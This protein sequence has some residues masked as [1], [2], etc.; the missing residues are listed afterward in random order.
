M[1][2]RPSL[3][4]IPVPIDSWDVFHHLFAWDTRPMS[5]QANPSDAVLP[6]TLGVAVRSFFAQGGRKC[7]V[8]SVGEPWPMVE[9]FASEGDRQTQRQLRLQALIPGYPYRVNG[10]AHD[11]NGWQGMTHLLGLTDVAFFCMPDVVELVVPNRIPINTERLTRDAPEIFIECSEIVGAATEDAPDR[12]TASLS[13]PR[14]D[15][16]AYQ[17]WASA[18]ALLATFIRNQ[19]LELQY[20]VAVPLPAVG[21]SVDTALSLLRQAL[22]TSEQAGLGRSPATFVQLAYPWVRS[23]SADALPEQLE[24][25]DAVLVGMLAR[26]A[27]TRGAFRSVVKQAAIGV[28]E[29][30]PA[31]TRVQRSLPSPTSPEP[32]PTLLQQVSLIGPT[33]SGIQVLSDQTFDPLDS[34]RP[35]SIHRLISL[36]IRALRQ[37]GHDHVFEPSGP[38]L[39]GQVRSQIT[40]LLTELWVAGALRG[41]SAAQAFQVRCD[42]STMTQADRDNGRVIA[43]IQVAPAAPVEQITIAL[44]LAEGSQV[45]RL[46]VTPVVEEVA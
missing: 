40:R 26:S 19:R 24:S 45:N 29:T 22:P 41:A 27:L 2:D 25:P 42:R 14:A 21:E 20:V 32:H 3:T 17:Q 8:V 33:P 46:S 1:G 34:Y 6:T 38:I 9:A 13:A 11:P 7:Y 43:L 28:S 18:V 36:I 10:S 31:L 12:S 37:F 16:I 35:A 39:W 44:N 30:V 15:P 23:L 5:T 4:N